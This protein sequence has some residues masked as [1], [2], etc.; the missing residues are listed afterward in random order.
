MVLQKPSKRQQEKFLKMMF[1]LR[2]LHATTCY[3][4]YSIFSSREQLSSVIEDYA[5]SFYQDNIKFNMVKDIVEKK[6]NIKISKI[7]DKEKVK[8]I[9]IFLEVFVAYYCEEITRDY[10]WF[11]SFRNEIME[12][13][14]NRLIRKTKWHVFT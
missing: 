14:Y 4:A 5:V 12:K 6:Y 7:K 11:K 2:K 1:F 8:E 13:V 9:E 3:I 10:L